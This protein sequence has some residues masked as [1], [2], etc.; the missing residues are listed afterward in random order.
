[1][2]SGLLFIFKGGTVV[3]LL[4]PF[5][6]IR[7]PPGSINQKPLIRHHRKRGSQQIMKRSYVERGATSSRPSFVYTLF[8]LAQAS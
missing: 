3:M 1:V 2:E 8:L 5:A 4:H 7:K 6:C